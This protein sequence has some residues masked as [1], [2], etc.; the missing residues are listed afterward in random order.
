MSKLTILDKKTFSVGQHTVDV[1]RQ[2]E[3]GSDK[4]H[5]TLVSTSIGDTKMVKLI[6]YGKGAPGNADCDF[7]FFDQA[8]AEKLVAGFKKFLT[9]KKGS[10]LVE[11]EAANA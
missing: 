5:Q 2:E 9:T 4:P 6:S 10:T 11:K 1:Q 3:D 8:K 7:S